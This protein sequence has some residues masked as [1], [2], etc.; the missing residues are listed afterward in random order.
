VG[1]RGGGELDESFRSDIRRP[2]EFLPSMITA[3]TKGMRP[4]SRPQECESEWREARQ[5][6]HNTWMH[7]IAGEQ[8]LRKAVRQRQWLFMYAKY[9][10]AGGGGKAVESVLYS[11]SV[12]DNARRR[13]RLRQDTVM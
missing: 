9:A 3:Q 10:T 1:E 12:Q 4:T 6:E 13:R 8:A 7:V 5:R 11:N 2:E